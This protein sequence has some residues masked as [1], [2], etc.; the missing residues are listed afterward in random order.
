MCSQLAESMMQILVLYLV[1]ALIFLIA[2][3]I[4]LKFVL[5]P[6]FEG[7]LADWLLDDIRIL[8]AVVFYLFYVAGLLWFVSV[9]ALRSGF[10]AQALVGGALLGALAYGTY[11]FTNFATLKSWS[12]NM[13]MIDVLWGAVLT[14]LSAFGGVI[15]ARSIA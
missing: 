14:G 11:E 3:A 9:P 15:I 13:V 10:P 8:P 12:I 7:Y 2:D 4:M 5:K 6:F 1:T